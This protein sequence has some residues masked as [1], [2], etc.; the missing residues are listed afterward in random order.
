[1]SEGEL[2]EVNADKLGAQQCIASVGDDHE[3]FLSKFKDRVDQYAGVG[4]GDALPA[5][6]ITERPICL[7]SLVAGDDGGGNTSVSNLGNHIGYYRL[8]TTHDARLFYFFFK[9]RRHK[10]GDPVV[11]WLTGGPGCS[12]ELA[13]FYENGPFHI[14]D[15]MSLLWNE[16]G[17]DQESNLIY[18]HQP[19][20]T[21]FNYSS[22]SHD[23][24]HNE[25]G[26]SND[27]YDFPQ[28]KS[29]Y[30]LMVFC[31]VILPYL[32]PLLSRLVMSLRSSPVNSV[33]TEVA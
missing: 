25:A 18:V 23:T 7:A 10:K 13:L 27:L 26:V 2:K 33:E 3:C 5:G 20:R 15:N 31:E 1:M 9:S 22:D 16:F 21:G 24:H 4:R 12:S 17:W 11:I 29:H 30:A 6:T 8:P 14:T 32:E 19:T 28:E